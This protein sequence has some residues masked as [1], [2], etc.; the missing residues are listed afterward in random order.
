[1]VTT[2]GAGA[3]V[4]LTEK[5][6]LIQGTDFWRY[7][8]DQASGSVIAEPRLRRAL[9]PRLQ[10]QGL[11]LSLSQPF[12]A[13]PATADDIP[14]R[15]QGIRVIEFP[16]W[17]V[18]QHPD[19]RALF[20]PLAHLLPESG[21]FKHPDCDYGGERHAVP[22]RFVA[23]CKH[24][25]L[26]EFP[27]LLFSHPD[28]PC[29]APRLRL[30]EGATGDF[31][32][33]RVRCA[34]GAER[35]L[36]DALVEQSNPGCRGLRPWL[37]SEAAE[38]CTER[39]RLLVRTATNTYFSHCESALSIPEPERDLEHR[40]AEVIELIGHATAQNLPVLRT[41][42]KVAQALG[43]HSDAEVL[44]II[45]RMNA[46][47][48][49][50]PEGLRT[51]EFRQ[52]LA[53]PEDQGEIPAPDEKFFARRCRV[54]G[55]SSDRDRPGRNGRTRL[56]PPQV[57]AVVLA[58]K[59]R[60]VRVQ[61]G[62]T[63]SEPVSPDLEGEFDLGVTL[64]RVGLHT[65]WLPASE[66]H[67]EGLFVRLDEN[68]VARWER[69][70]AVRARE[71]DLAAG[72]RLSAERGDTSLAF[73]GARF[74]LLHSLSHLLITAISLEC[75][76]SASAIHERIYCARADQALPM[77]AILLS[78]GTPGSEGTLGGLV[79]QGPVLVEHL[80]RAFDMAELCA[81]DPLCAAHDPN[82]DHAER[83]LEGAACHG[84]LY[85]A[86]PACERFNRYL[87]RALV[88]PTLG[89]DRDLAF[90]QER[91]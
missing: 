85:V 77:A 86:E 16:A 20:R 62:F 48:T 58:R 61:L 17:F 21:P 27:W 69:R 52:F 83:F 80:G 72:H 41:I 60:E 19:C 11:E 39:L 45:E 47:E 54:P 51:A 8:G 55:K 25:H 66:I 57:A 40:V 89:H 23:T 35:S 67:G 1:V 59:L 87:D 64:A 56:L 70:D 26:E 42:P 44:R 32:E 71:R 36:S 82:G 91:P 18:C 34:C 75:G 28:G 68:E 22:V 29:E 63:R 50:D 6:V 2:F 81:N 88:V 7:H 78:T 79:E 84:C 5:S 53:Q 12:R 43:D 65:D 73:P 24:G 90:F 31:A 49:E 37:G 14:S 33:I 74:Y 38:P 9:A 10:A 4:D 3:M 46:G 13:P 30:D 15:G 76:Y